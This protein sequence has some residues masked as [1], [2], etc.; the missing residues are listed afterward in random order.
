M[1][2]GA[3]ALFRPPAAA[4]DSYRPIVR[5]FLFCVVPKCPT[6]WCRSV[7]TLRHQ[8][9]GT[10]VSWCQSVLWPKCPAPVQFYVQ[11]YMPLSPAAAA[12]AESAARVIRAGA[13]RV[14]WIRHP[15]L[16][17]VSVGCCETSQ[18]GIDIMFYSRWLA[19]IGHCA[20][21]PGRYTAISKY[22]DRRRCIT[23]GKKQRESRRLRAV[24]SEWLVSVVW[25]R[26]IKPTVGAIRLQR[27]RSINQTHNSNAA[28]CQHSRA[29]YVRGLSLG[30]YA[31]RRGWP[32]VMS[33]ASN[34]AV[35]TSAS[36][37]QLP[38]LTFIWYSLQIWARSVVTEYRY[39][40]LTVVP[41]R[42][43][44]YQIDVSHGAW[45]GWHRPTETGCIF[46]QANSRLLSTAVKH[47]LF[48]STALVIGTLLKFRATSELIGLVYRTFSS[49]FLEVLTRFCD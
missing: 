20:T 27:C 4:T 34:Y 6:S 39:K 10:E 11:W 2:P 23:E 47:T 49:T 8:F 9:C 31:S 35:F 45:I 15:A 32:V 1:P 30:L 42:E 33:L 14:R 38:R 24:R 25:S 46:K 21:R 18:A 16:A 22:R 44:L 40:M 43:N 19:I 48:K 17:R 36:A 29:R 26:P 12:A 37:P 7:R 13:R 5:F 41:P 28:K 3:L